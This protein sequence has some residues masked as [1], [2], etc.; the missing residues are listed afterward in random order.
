MS[1]GKRE[2]GRFRGEGTDVDRV[3]VEGAQGRE[4]SPCEEMAERAA[5]EAEQGVVE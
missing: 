4:E 5:G 2:E 3:E 1:P